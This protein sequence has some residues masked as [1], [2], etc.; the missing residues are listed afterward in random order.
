MWQI[1]AYKRTILFRLFRWMDV[2]WIVWEP[3]ARTRKHDHGKSFGWVFAI[4]GMFFEI[5]NGKVFTARSPRLFFELP[6]VPHIAGNNSMQQKSGSLHI[7]IP[8]LQ[9]NFF[10]DSQADKELLEKVSIS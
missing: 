7:Y 1:N 6:T 2:V 5:K 10:E 3:E 9:M 4:H 8:S